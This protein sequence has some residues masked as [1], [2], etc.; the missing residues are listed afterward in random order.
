MLL[1]ILCLSSS[2]AVNALTDADRQFLKKKIIAR[3]EITGKNQIAAAYARGVD[4]MEDSPSYAAGYFTVLV[5]ED[6][7][8]ALRAD[9]YTLEVLEDDWYTSFAAKSPSTM[10]GFK[11]WTEGLAFLD[12]LH[13][14]YPAITTPK[15]SIGFTFEGRQ[16]FAMKISDNPNIDE[17]EPEILFDA[18]HHAREPITC[19]VLYETMRQLCFGYGSDSLMT[20]FVDNREIYFI[21]FVNPDG[22]E[23]NR[24]IAPAGGGMWRKNRNNFFEPDFGVDPNRNYDNNWG[25][26]DEGSSPN[27]PSETYRGM[28]PASEFEVQNM[29][30]FID[31]R[32]FIMQMSY[33]SYSNLF[34]W[35]PGYDS[36]YAPDQPL[37][38]AI[39]DSVT[40]YNGYKPEPIWGLYLTNGTAIEWSHFATANHSKVYAFTPEVGSGSDGFWPNPARIPALVAE[41]LGPNWVIID[42]ADTPERI[43]P[44]VPPTWLDPDSATSPDYVLSWSDPGGLN[45]AMSFRVR[46]LYGLSLG[47][48]DAEVFNG[49]WGFSGFSQS[50]TRA[51][52]GMKSYYSAT[53]NGL[54]SRMNSAVPTIVGVNDTLKARIWWDTETDW[55]Y[56]YAE[57]SADNGQSWATLAGNFT[58]N[59]NPNGTNR[60]NGITGYAGSGGAFLQARFP[61]NA[62]AGDTVTIRFSYET[63]NFAFGEG[64]YVDDITPVFSYDSAVVLAES[65]P[66]ETFPV[67]GKAPGTYWYDL[68]STDSQ[69]QISRTTLPHS[70]N[71]DYVTCSCPCHAD[72]ICDG[73]TNVQDVVSVIDIA[74]RGGDATVDGGCDHDPAGRSDVNCD[75]ATSVLD[76][77]RMVNVTFRGADAATEFC[78]PCAL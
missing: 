39:G 46:E 40:K 47:V 2:S 64:A 16:Q 56:V 62:Y 11:T 7:L 57:I 28:S 12:S 20:F 33:H 5:S 4:I 26:D 55:D 27:P 41:N 29:Q 77:V 54:S 44:P 59:S 53:G 74:F 72:P 18:L 10:G 70:V 75:G 6:E 24:T 71:V 13:A 34:L 8:A 15:F 78:D 60:G 35:P 30:N 73:F 52:S 58:T 69:G 65:T 1:L 36:V 21:P 19:E 42:L 14:A 43:Y 25:F 51:F 63:D 45:A 67:T 37:F 49:T 66:S 50:G 32:E 38:S 22:Y 76:V 17:S 9:G 68:R 61:L 31:G 3:W 23:Y 48:D